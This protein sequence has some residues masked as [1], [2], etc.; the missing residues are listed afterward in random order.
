MI[1][2]GV[3]GDGSLNVSDCFPAKAGKQIGLPPSRENK[4]EC[5]SA[6]RAHLQP[7]TTP[8][9]AGVVVEGGRF[10]ASRHPGES[11]DPELRGDRLWLWVLTF[12]STTGVCSAPVGRSPPDPFVL[13]EV[14]A[15]S[16]GD[17]L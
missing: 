11:Q 5:A 4:E 14:E 13:N 12:V 9:F 2:W 6:I 1:V 10:R 17:A 7:H 3:M 8:A 16:P 15:L